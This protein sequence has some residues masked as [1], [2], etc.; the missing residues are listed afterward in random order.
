MTDDGCTTSIK[1]PD[2]RREIAGDGATAGSSSCFVSEES[3]VGFAADVSVTLSCGASEAAWSSA[4]LAGVLISG[5]TT[6]GLV[7]EAACGNPLAS[8]DGEAVSLVDDSCSEVGGS[9]CDSLCGSSSLDSG[10]VDRVG[11]SGIEVGD[12]GT[13]DEVV[14]NDGIGSS[15]SF[16][17]GFGSGFVTEI[18]T[19]VGASVA[20]AAGDAL[21]VFDEADD[22]VVLAGAG[23]LLVSSLVG[24][25]AGTVAMAEAEAGVGDAGA[26]TGVDSG[27]GVDA[28]AAVGDGGVSGLM[29]N[30]GIGVDGVVTGDGGVDE[31]G[32]AGVTDEDGDGCVDV[33][34]GFSIGCGAAATGALGG[35]DNDTVGCG[36]TG[37]G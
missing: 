15:V 24:S 12:G 2:G 3:S 17:T 11:G 6:A 16:E 22:C 5:N 35:V 26:D 32:A 20:A 19:A 1:R 21:G 28:G 36:A 23:G 14:L 7:S 13:G 33:S 10:V 29:V 25:D 8:V 31:A 37:W 4:F 9:P 30:G 34:S 27:A 18:G